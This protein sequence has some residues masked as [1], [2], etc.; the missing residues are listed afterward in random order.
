MDNKYSKDFNNS[1]PPQKLARAR[2]VPCKKFN[3]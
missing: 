1:I 3:K 2:C